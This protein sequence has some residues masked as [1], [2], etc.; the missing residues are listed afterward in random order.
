MLIMLIDSRSRTR[1]Y[2]PSQ[3]NEAS[4]TGEAQFD[5]DSAQNLK[6]VSFGEILFAKTHYVLRATQQIIQEVEQGVGFTI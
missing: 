5:F 4:L 3:Q 2:F 1:S 6:K